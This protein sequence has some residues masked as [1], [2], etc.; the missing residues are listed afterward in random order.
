[1]GLNKL[2]EKQ[3]KNNNRNTLGIESIAE[4]APWM[5]EEHINK[6]VD[7][8]TEQ[9]KT[10]TYINENMRARRLILPSQTTQYVILP[11]IPP[12]PSLRGGEGFRDRVRSGVPS[13]SE[14]NGRWGGNGV[15]A[16][17]PTADSDSCLLH[18]T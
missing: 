12:P 3:N 9:G 13:S 2:K 10:K 16:E 4:R 5:S 18:S 7:A 6:L 15:N 8:H 11:D 1:M 17:D 14:T